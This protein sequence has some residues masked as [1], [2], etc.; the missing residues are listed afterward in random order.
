[1]TALSGIEIARRVD[2]EDR[3]QQ[4]PRGATFQRVL[5]WL[6]LRRSSGIAAAGPCHLRI[7]SSRLGAFLHDQ[8]DGRR[9]ETSRSSAPSPTRRWRPPGRCPHPGRRPRRCVF[10]TVKPKIAGA[11]RQ[12]ME[13]RFQEFR[14]AYWED[15]QTNKNHLAKAPIGSMVI[16][17]QNASTSTQINSPSGQTPTYSTNISTTGFDNPE[18]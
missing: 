12:N 6:R 18:E 2:V 17:R 7:R 16:E 11:F 9:D 4:G 10:P 15:H 13:M 8:T 5:V 1:M 3:I 14:A